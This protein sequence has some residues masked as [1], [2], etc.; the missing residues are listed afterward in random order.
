MLRKRLKLQP[1]TS[2]DINSKGKTYQIN[3][4]SSLCLDYALEFPSAGVTNYVNIRGMRSLTQ[5]TLCFCMKS[6]DTSNDGTPFSYAVPGEDNELLVFNYKAFKVFIRGES[7]LETG[8]QSAK[9]VYHFSLCFH[10]K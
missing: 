9:T 4:I 6:S 2:S 1:C 3:L 5:F 10:V 7:R 8:R